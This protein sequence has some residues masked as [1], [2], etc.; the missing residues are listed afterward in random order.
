LESLDAT[1]YAKGIAF[2]RLDLKGI[3]HNNATNRQGKN[4]TQSKARK[5]L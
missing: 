4:I 1:D 2:I 5:L 3:L